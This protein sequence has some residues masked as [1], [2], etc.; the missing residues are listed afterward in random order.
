M[1]VVRFGPA[2]NSTSFYE[3]GHKSSL[4]VPS[5]LRG[6]GLDAYEYQC[7]RGVNIKEETARKLG[8]LARESGISL[9]VHAPYYINLA[10]TK[11]EVREKTKEHFLKTLR[12][13]WWMGA[14]VVV[15]H[16]GSAGDGD[17][18]EA[19][20]RAGEFLLE[21]L[22]EAEMEGIGGILVAPETMGKASQLG[23]LRE[24]LYLCT[25]APQRIVPALDFGH[26][27][28]AGLGCLES[29]EDFAKI[30]DE[31]VDVLGRSVVEHL[32]VHFSPVEFTRAGEK[33][34]RTALE[35]EFGPDFKPLAELLVERDIGATIIC[36]SAGRQAEDALLYRD[37]YLKVRTEIHGRTP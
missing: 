24:V 11:P 32:H 36:E 15:F 12:V 22:S 34:H 18:E 35:K 26:L 13:G 27:Y 29:K 9:S 14:S 6:M 7:S 31:V 19:L 5:W 3:Q 16:P 2:G 33:R 28:A 21:I 25:L 17:R 4:E 23:N 20:R 37:I 10:T 1:V 30:L 8:L